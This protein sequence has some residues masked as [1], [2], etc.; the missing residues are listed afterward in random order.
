M[1]TTGLQKVKPYLETPTFTQ[2]SWMLM[3]N[4]ELKNLPDF[5]L[6][7]LSLDTE[8]LTGATKLIN[9][10]A[11]STVNM[12]NNTTT[13]SNPIP[14]QKEETLS[15]QELMILTNSGTA[16]LVMIL[17]EI[18]KIIIK[19]ASSTITTTTQEQ[20]CGHGSESGSQLWIGK[21]W[22]LTSS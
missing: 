3:K 13:G 10:V 9:W 5:G 16:L 21:V 2:P 11:K 6:T 17:V 4:T 1:E 7:I 14:C 18:I 8:T 22:Q 12:D 20:A 19:E 15:L